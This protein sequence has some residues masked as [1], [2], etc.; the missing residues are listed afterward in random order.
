[1]LHYVF[2]KEFR[3]SKPNMAVLEALCG[4]P[5]TETDTLEAIFDAYQLKSVMSHANCP[6]TLRKAA[7]AAPLPAPKADDD[8]AWH[9][10][11]GPWMA[12]RLQ[13][14]AGVK[15]RLEL[16]GRFNKKALAGFERYFLS[17][18]EPAWNQANPG[19]DDPLPLILRLWFDPDHGRARWEAIRDRVLAYPDAGHIRNSLEQSR[20]LLWQADEELYSGQDGAP[21]G[22]MGGVEQAM[23]DFLVGPPGNA[24]AFQF[25]GE[26]FTFHRGFA[27]DK[28][29][30]RSASEWLRNDR[31]RNS[32]KLVRYAVEHAFHDIEESDLATIGADTHK[33]AL[34]KLY[35]K[36][37]GSYP[38]PVAGA[39]DLPR[40]LY[41]QRVRELL[42]TAPGLLQTWWSRFKP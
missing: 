32:Y 10:K 31:P 22:F 24:T 8:G 3:S 27:L 39:I 36:G 11:D 38:A 29:H 9:L 26:N 16:S 33:L 7:L 12:A 21:D 4:N 23:F 20:A 41:C 35:L 40:Q 17:G 42:A 2:V 15:Q 6:P 14:W 34:L 25:H 30:Y 18:R 37:V 5:A 13:L 28:S 1:V 19:Q